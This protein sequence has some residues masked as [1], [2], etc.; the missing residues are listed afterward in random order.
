MRVL[1]IG[2]ISRS[3]ST[4]LE[5]V[6]GELPDTC[7]VGEVGNLWRRGLRDD[8]QCGCGCRFS[9]C[10]FWQ[11]VGEQA[12]GGWQKVDPHRVTSLKRTVERVRHLPLLARPKLTTGWAAVV[13]EYASYYTRVY[14]AAAALT[15]ART[16]VDSS[17]SAM[18]ALTLRWAPDLDLRVVHL[19]RDPRGVAH[20]LT[21]RVPRL[22]GSPSAATMMRYPPART[23]LEWNLFNGA[24][25]LLGRLPGTDVGRGTGGGPRCVPVTRIRYEEFLNDPRRV[26]GD[27]ASY[28][29]IDATDAALSYLTREHAE[30]GTVH[31]PSGNPMR[32][33]TGRVSLRR[34]DAWRASLPSR[35]RWLVNAMCAPLLTAYG[36]PL[37]VPHPRDCA[38]L[39][40]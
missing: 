26:V 2:G 17:K 20:S 6:L 10:E 28:A 22:P 32:F 4:L 3:G 34:D 1:F 7:A 36:F 9:A 27:V 19:V 13:E 39:P 15:G 37:R 40:R 33:A 38:A 11:A 25:D 21:K 18:L 35:H 16:V 29:G 24:F 12:F 14:A 8:E 30:L 5:R 31:N 23:A